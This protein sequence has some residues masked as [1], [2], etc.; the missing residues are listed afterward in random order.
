MGRF[1]FFPMISAVSRARFRGEEIIMS[2]SFVAVL[3][4][5]SVCFI[6]FS[7]RLQSSFFPRA[8]L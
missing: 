2:Y 4:K 8:I 6:P 3:R 1:H 7:F 5:S